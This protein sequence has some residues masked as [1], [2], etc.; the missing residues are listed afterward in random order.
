MEDKGNNCDRG[1]QIMSNARRWVTSAGREMRIKDM[2]DIHLCNATRMIMR[3]NFRMTYL[4]DMFREIRRR[5]L[6]FS[7]D[8]LYPN[9]NL[10]FISEAFR[11]STKAERKIMV[12]KP[13]A[14]KILRR[15]KF[16]ESDT[17]ISQESILGASSL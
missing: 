1:L 12:K 15:P 5:K 2:G 6:D 16:Y 7:I 4:E 14:Y 10:P 9:P 17:S 13:Q 3:R 8:I 11:L